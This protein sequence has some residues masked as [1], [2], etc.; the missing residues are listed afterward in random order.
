MGSSG[1]KGVPK[2]GFADITVL[3]QIKPPNKIDY[4]IKFTRD[5]RKYKVSY[6]DQGERFKKVMTALEQ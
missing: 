5:N 4:E 3:I 6:L 2:V 1:E